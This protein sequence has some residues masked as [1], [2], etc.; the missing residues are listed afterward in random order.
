M[1]EKRIL[2]EQVSKL[3]RD[4]ESLMNNNKEVEYDV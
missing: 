4:K 3:V 1:T 2:S